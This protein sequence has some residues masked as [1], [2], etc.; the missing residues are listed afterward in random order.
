ML[1]AFQRFLQKRCSQ[2]GDSGLAQHSAIPASSSVLSNGNAQLLS[3]CCKIGLV[4]LLSL[5]SGASSCLL[6]QPVFCWGGHIQ[7]ANFQFR[8]CSLPC[9]KHSVA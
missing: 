1:L 7:G 5:V 3:L 6:Y 8:V 2:D 4:V 9:S